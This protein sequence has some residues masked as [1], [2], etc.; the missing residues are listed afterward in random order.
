MNSLVIKSALL[1]YMHVSLDN[2]L[3]ITQKKEKK[4]SGVN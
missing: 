1:Q 3:F 4:D 2:N